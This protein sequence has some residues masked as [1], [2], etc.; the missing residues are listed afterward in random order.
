MQQFDL[1]IAALFLCYFPHIFVYTCLYTEAIFLLPLFSF[2]VFV[3]H[4]VCSLLCVFRATHSLYVST[5]LANKLDSDS[6]NSAAIFC[7]D[8]LLKATGNNFARSGLININL[9]EIIE[10]KNKKQ[11]VKCLIWIYN[12]DLFVFRARDVNIM[13]M[14]DII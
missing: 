2:V 5:Q 3:S 4:H 10:K 11:F 9:Y 1:Y 12:I 6:D 13:E 8:E 7:V 14:N